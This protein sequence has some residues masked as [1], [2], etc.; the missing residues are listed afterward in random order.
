M[1]KKSTELVRSEGH[2][3]YLPKLEKEMRD[4]MQD[5]AVVDQSRTISE[6]VQQPGGLSEMINS[7]DTSD[8][9]SA[10]IY[11][12][13]TFAAVANPRE[14][15]KDLWTQNAVHYIGHLMAVSGHNRYG[16]VSMKSK[17][18][19]PAIRKFIV[20]EASEEMDMEGV[21]GAL[22]NDFNRLAHMGYQNVVKLVLFD[23]LIN[24][25][26]LDGGEI[27]L[28]H[29]EAWHQLLLKRA[30]DFRDG[31]STFN[32]GWRDEQEYDIAEL[33]LDE[34]E[35]Y[36]SYDERE[37]DHIELTLEHLDYL[38]D[39]DEFLPTYMTV[40][41]I[42]RNMIHVDGFCKLVALEWIN[43]ISE[44]RTSIDRFIKQGMATRANR[45]VT[46]QV[47]KVFQK[48]LET[49]LRNLGV[50]SLNLSVW[51]RIQEI[52]QGRFTPKP[53]RRVRRKARPVT[54]TRLSGPK[55]VQPESQANSTND[56]ADFSLGD[57]LDLVD[58]EK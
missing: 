40:N 45:V 3:G 9:E 13:A 4:Q 54:T 11:S 51:S 41:I 27:N 55:V 39:D 31:F 36:Q 47:A 25:I 32:N 22:L 21:L 37:Y 35:N 18:Y 34:L 53:K 23:I 58:Y 24:S 26:K 57:F 52:L 2:T 17:N 20:E 6:R 19:V 33:D 46:V 48:E 8:V 28:G 50:D 10:L 30:V 7:I 49:S 15:P 29:K 14:I 16:E 38:S 5:L 1:S 44:E 42:L 43:Y 12:Q 56:I